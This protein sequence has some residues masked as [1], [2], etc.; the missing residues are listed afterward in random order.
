MEKRD[1]GGEEGV[2][3]GGNEE[4]PDFRKVTPR[5]RCAFVP[6]RPPLRELWWLLLERDWLGGEG[7]RRRGEWDRGSKALKCREQTP[8]M[9][10]C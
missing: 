7:S 2:P 5:F 10:R 3:E 6:Q 8:R 4:R 9:C 1:T